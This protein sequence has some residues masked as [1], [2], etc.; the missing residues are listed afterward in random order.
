[1]LQHLWGSCAYPRVVLW[2]SWSS[3]VAIL[4]QSYNLEHIYGY[5]YLASTWIRTHDLWVM[6]L[7][8]YPLDY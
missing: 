7:M 6:R 3:S 1:M 2:Q 8:P 4:K 5:F